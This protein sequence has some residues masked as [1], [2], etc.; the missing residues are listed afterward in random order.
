MRLLTRPFWV[1]IALAFLLEAWLWDHLEPIAARIV[2][3]FPLRR[4]KRKLAEWIEHLPPT[5][6]L[7]VF[8]LPGVLLFPFKLIG[9]YLLAG[10]YWLTAIVLF[11]LAKLVGLGFAAFV[12][13]L[14]RPKL[15]QIAWFRVVYE[16]VIAWRE[17]A[18][19]EVRPIKR[20]IRALMYL[21]QPHRTKKL[22]RRL[23]RLRRKMN[24]PAP[25]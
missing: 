15:L 20:R 23:V 17:W 1:V 7:I 2:A 21:S 16:H 4:L 6:T 5:A 10:G 18:Q 11:T 14:T 13:D 8:A 3:V 9:L 25:A 22:I 19:N 24:R 12:F